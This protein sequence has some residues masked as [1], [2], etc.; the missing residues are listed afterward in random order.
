MTM[1][2]HTHNCT[3]PDATCE[4]GFVF[5]VPRFSV[6]FDVSDGAGLLLQDAFSS[7]SLE[8]IID[9]LREAADDLERKA[10]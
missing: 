1:A 4:C 7:D 8:T 9:A 3:G 10:R 2:Q 6:S 5:R